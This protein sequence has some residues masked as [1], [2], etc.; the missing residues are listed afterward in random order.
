MVKMRTNPSSRIGSPAKKSKYDQ[1]LVVLDGY[2][3]QSYTADMGDLFC[4]CHICKYEV[5]CEPSDLPDDKEGPI[6]FVAQLAEEEEG[7]CYCHICKYEVLCEPSDLP[8]DKDGPIK[9]V[10]QSA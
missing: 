5:L 4:Y 7:F 1:S 9:F 3:I 8:D 10:P 6:K 2:V